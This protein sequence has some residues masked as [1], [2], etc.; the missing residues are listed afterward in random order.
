MPP[1]PMWSYMLSLPRVTRNSSEMISAKA[2][3]PNTTKLN[4]FS[5]MAKTTVATALCTVGLLLIASHC[6]TLPPG[7]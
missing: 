2:T 4:P 5:A 7:D 1:C 3:V 6:A